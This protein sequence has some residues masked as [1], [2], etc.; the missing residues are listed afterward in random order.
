M[1]TGVVLLEELALGGL[2]VYRD[3][4]SVLRT[5]VGAA[6]GSLVLGKSDKPQ[7]SELA[8]ISAGWLVIFG[9]AALVLGGSSIA[10]IIEAFLGA[11]IVYQVMKI[12]G[13]SE[14]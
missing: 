3:G 12:M 10:P 9:L 8:G 6:D 1:S 2:L 5:V 4:G 14:K 13:G 11:A 7:P